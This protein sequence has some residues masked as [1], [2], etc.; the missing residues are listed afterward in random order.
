MG[1]RCALSAG[2]RGTRRGSCQGARR[3]TSQQLQ[4]DDEDYYGSASALHAFVLASLGVSSER[5]MRAPRPSATSRGQ[6]MQ[7]IT[8]GTDQ[9][10]AH[11]HR[12]SRPLQ[13]APPRTTH[14]E[15]TPQI[16]PQCRPTTSP[17]SRARHDE[18]VGSNHNNN[19][20]SLF[21]HIINTA[22]SAAA[23]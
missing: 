6:Q 17:R 4:K 22:R 11:T 16:P 12:R 7:T 3:S 19:F 14:A 9:T 20:P 1:G 8:T 18:R 13:C 10:R 2:L 21:K 5:T 23:A 15:H